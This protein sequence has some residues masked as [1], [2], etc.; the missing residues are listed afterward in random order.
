MRMPTET[1]N[2]DEL[3]LS[4]GLHTRALGSCMTCC[5]IFM[6]ENLCGSASGNL[7]DFHDF[8]LKDPTLLPIVSSQHID[9]VVKKSMTSDS[10]IAV[11]WHQGSSI[12]NC[13]DLR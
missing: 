4:I 13:K 9:K 7:E 5:K 11:I 10:C 8:H 12:I 2:S 3:E 1:E 6:V